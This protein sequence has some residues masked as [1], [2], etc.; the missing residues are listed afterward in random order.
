MEKDNIYTITTNVE[1]LN[2]DAHCHEAHHQLI[3]MIKGTLHIK[4][5]D[6]Q[7][8]LPEHF[9]GIIPANKIHELQ[10]RNEMVKMFLVYFPKTITLEGFLQLSANDFVVNNLRYLS[11]LP[12]EIS[13]GVNKQHFNFAYA[14]LD[15][16]KDMKGLQAFPLKGFLAPKNERLKNVLCYIEQNYTEKI[17][18]D[19]VAAKF[20][21]SVRNLT[22][23]FKKE[24]ISFNNHVNYLR[25]IH[26]I[27]KF[28][29]SNESIEKIAFE[30]GYGTASNFS[31]TFK[32]HT[33]FTPREFIKVNT[34]NSFTKQGEL[35]TMS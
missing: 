1:Y 2:L 35:V 18:L 25:I 21:F 34:T 11:K 28:T 16:L 4:V 31:R 33:G 14:F 27:E 5:D 7:Y 15:L 12:D 23:L 22:R 8:F 19:S 3:Y 32:K 13:K 30:V 9:I 10:S 24:N 29:D 20:G 17:T 26:A 6:T